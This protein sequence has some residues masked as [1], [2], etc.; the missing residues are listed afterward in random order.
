V[1]A[2]RLLPFAAPAAAGIA[3]TSGGPAIVLSIIGAVVTL[4]LARTVVHRLRDA[5]R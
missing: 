4:L 5:S 2:V 1:Y 3:V